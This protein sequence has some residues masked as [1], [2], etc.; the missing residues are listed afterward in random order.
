VIECCQ[1]VEPSPGGQ[2]TAMQSK[3]AVKWTFRCQSSG[4]REDRQRFEVYDPQ[5]AAAIRPYMLNNGW[6]KALRPYMHRL[7]RVFPC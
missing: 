7:T 3:D 5:I 1:L 2:E 4:E 6:T